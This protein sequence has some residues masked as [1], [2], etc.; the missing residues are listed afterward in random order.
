MVRNRIRNNLNPQ[1][2]SATI[3]C[4]NCFTSCLRAEFSPL[5]S[6]TKCWYFTTFTGKAI[7]EEFPRKLPTTS[8]RYKRLILLMPTFDRSQLPCPYRY[9][10]YS[11]FTDAGEYVFDPKTDVGKATPAG[12]ISYFAGQAAKV[13]LACT[14]LMWSGMCILIALYGDPGLAC[15]LV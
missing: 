6:Q 8:E 15:V 13:C 11:I 14:S 9:L 5:I 10:S 3:T 1:P 7:K 2:H 4:F 12:P